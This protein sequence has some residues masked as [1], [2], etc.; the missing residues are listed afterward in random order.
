MRISI[1]YPI[2]GP[3]PGVPIILPYILGIFRRVG[4]MKLYPAR[5]SDAFRI[6]GVFPIEI[7]IESPLPACVIFACEMFKGHGRRARGALGPRDAD[8][9]IEE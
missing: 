7:A 8:R 2:H 3:F 5:C 1:A 4:K 6:H 9:A